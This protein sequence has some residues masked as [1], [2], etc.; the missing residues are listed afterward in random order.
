MRLLMLSTLAALA[1]AIVVPAA[2]AFRFTDEAR[3]VPTGTVG[4][5]YSHALTMVGGC[6]LVTMRT[7]GSFPHGLRLVG[8]PSEETQNSWRIEGTP[9]APGA[10]R[11]WIIAGSEW[12]ECQDDSTEEEW[13]IRID[14]PAIPPLIV[15]SNSVAPAVAGAAYTARLTATGGASQ[16]WSV[17][18]GALPAGVA[19]QPDGTLT[20]TPQAEGTFTFTARVSDGSQSASAQF[21]LLVRLPLQAL[22]PAPP[23]TEVG[24]AT[25][26]AMAATGGVGPYRWELVGGALPAGLVLD[27]PTGGLIGTPLVPGRYPLEL[28]VSGS[29]GQTARIGFTLRVNRRLQ[30]VRWPLTAMKRGRFAVRRM[31]ATGGV[32][33]RQWKVVRGR[34]PVGI[35]MN[36][37]N[38]KLLGTPRQPGRFVFTV[39]VIDSNGV[40]AFRT[41]ALRVRG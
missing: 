8:S 36:I 12:P 16:R 24:V 22:V 23:I 20:G 37:R 7:E 4:R 31:F 5:A 21:S 15:T 33:P 26:I 18:A 28:Q 14:P 17:A 34:F 13:T 1:A 38:G 39:R 32:G 10:Y 3:N 30:V 29:A 40:V 25:R 27:A 2:S 41:F 9:T 11:F 19:L 6:K 35:R